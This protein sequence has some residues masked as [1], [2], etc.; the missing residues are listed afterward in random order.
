M[1]NVHIK[2][3]TLESGW[4]AKAPFNAILS[5]SEFKE[6]PD[7]IKQQ[8]KIGAKLLAPVGPDW[9]H[10]M[11]ETIERISETEYKSNRATR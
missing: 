2:T 6:I 9:A 11:L 3:G 5:A 4:K 10:V 1:T 8:L 7:A